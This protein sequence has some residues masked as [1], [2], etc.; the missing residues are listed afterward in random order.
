VLNPIDMLDLII[1]ILGLS[2]I[3]YALLGG[4]DFGAG[5]IETFAGERGERTISKAMAP[6]W[7]ANHVWLILAVVILF[8]G[9]PLV[10]SSLSLVLHI[11]LMLVLLG[12][13]ARGTAFTFR[14]YDVRETSSHKYYSFLFKLSSFLTPMFLGITLGAM[15]LGRITFDHSAGFYSMFISPWLNLFCIM[16][17]VFSTSLFA[18]I[19]AAFLVGEANTP[20][21]KLRYIKL[22]R[23]FLW[24]TA[25]IGLMVFAAAEIQGHELLREFLISPVSIGCLLLAAFLVPLVLYHL[26]KNIRITRAFIG[27]QVS[28]IILGW[29]AIQY[30]VLIN[31]K[32]DEPLTF[33]NT[34]APPSTLMQLLIALIVGLL[35][36]IPGF[37]FL[38]RVFKRD[39]KR[40]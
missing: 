27:L 20:I 29:F 33:L 3:L 25:A 28:S 4:A 23:K 38:F 37:L 9:F 11:P 30:P 39:Y 26:N 5:I 12:I 1:I 8:T 21:E 13:I 31:I 2:F 24:I 6:V 17:G 19:A 16:M 15:I 14:H 32:N 10:Y 34:Q 22:S 35:L 18:Y 36:V 7:E 40:E